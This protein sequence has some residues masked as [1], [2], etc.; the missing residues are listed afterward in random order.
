MP[1]CVSYI[2]VKFQTSSYNTFWDM[3]FYLV[4]NF[5]KSHNDEEKIFLE[6]SSYSSRIPLCMS[7][8]VVKFHTSSYKTFWDMNFYLVWIFVKSQ[9]DRQTDRQKVTH[10]SQPCIF[11]QVGS[12]KLKPVRTEADARRRWQYLKLS[13]LWAG[14]RKKNYVD[15]L[16]KYWHLDHI[17]NDIW[18]DPQIMEPGIING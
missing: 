11:T 16:G 9:T 7:Y 5:V 12:I 4:S 2:V 15:Y 18:C 10:M 17:L 13:C 14:K 6:C 3:N 1:L 8:T